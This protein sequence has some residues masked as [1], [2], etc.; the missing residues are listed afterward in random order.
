[1]IDVKMHLDP[2]GIQNVIYEFNECSTQ[3][4]AKAR[5]FFCKHINEMLRFE[6]LD[7]TNPNILQNHLKEIF[8]HQKEVILPNCRDEWRILRFQ[9]FKKVNEYNSTLF[10]MCSQLKY[11]GHKVTDEDVLEKT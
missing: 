5:V 11:Y 2:I 6:Y 7:I 10:R 3:E 8:N 9:D 1:M 4:K